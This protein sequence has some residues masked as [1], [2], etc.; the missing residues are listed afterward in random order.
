LEYVEHD[1]LCRG[2]RHASEFVAKDRGFGNFF[3]IPWEDDNLS[4]HDVVQMYGVPAAECVSRDLI[5]YY[6]SKARWVG[7][8]LYYSPEGL[9]ASVMV[10]QSESPLLRGNAIY[11]EW[12]GLVR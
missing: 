3:L 6:G 8:Q 10:T 2:I 9:A 7:V 1:L 12:V 4:Y 5:K 11:S